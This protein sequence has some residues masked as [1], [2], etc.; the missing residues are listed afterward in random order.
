MKIRRFCALWLAAGMLLCTGCGA[1][2]APAAESS[3]TAANDYTALDPALLSSISMKTAAATY[4]P[5]A[6]QIDVVLENSGGTDLG[7][8]ATR[9][10]LLRYDGDTAE[11]IPN[12][13]GRGCCQPDGGTVRANS[14]LTWTVYFSE[15]GLNALSAGEYALT[16]GDCE[17]SFTIAE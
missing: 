13:G 12:I 7:F 1:D 4:A 10:Q 17:A 11:I 5:D 8:A 2:T 14:S 15:F 3:V 16:L 6:A 9:F